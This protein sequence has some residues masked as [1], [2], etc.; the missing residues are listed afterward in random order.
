MS[1][2][3]P[4]EPDPPHDPPPARG[5]AG[6]PVV[7][8]LSLVAAG[9]LAAL[10][11][12]FIVDRATHSRTEDVFVEAHIVNIAPQLVSGRIIRVMADENDRV[13]AGQVLAEIDPIPYQDKV[14][15]A[16]RKLES[17]QAQHRMAAANLAKARK[18]VP[19]Q[20][21]ISKRNHATAIADRAKAEKSL[22]LTRQQ[23]AQGIDE[24]QAGVKSARADLL[25]AD[26]QYGRYTRLYQ[27][28]ASTQQKAQEATQARESAAAQLELAETKL[29]TALSQR[30]KVDVADADLDAAHAGEGKAAQNISLSETG[31]DQLRAEEFQVEVARREVAQAEEAL[32]SA[33]HDLDYTRIRA[34]FPGV[35]VKRYRNLG[36]FAAPGSS[37]LSMVNPDLLYVEANLEETRLPGVAPGN[38]VTIHIDAFDRPFEGRVLWINK[39]TGAEFALMPRNVVSGE[40]THVVQRVAVRIWIKPDGRWDQLRA[41]LSAHIE[42]AHSGSDPEWARRTARELTALETR[43]N[44]PPAPDSPA[45]VLAPPPAGPVQR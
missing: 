21:E 17:A 18:D 40:F 35:V 9:V 34:P 42:I 38:P 31:Y 30:L 13:D 11:V 20:V 5:I 28:E 12:V 32:R 37:V 14:A 7:I 25:L 36:D 4:T 8:T 33:Q 1:A 23:V 26:E 27:Q 24:A 6:R 16:R 10:L 43:Y 39:S 3:P 22:T 44:Q 41:G 45:D 15:E 19:I 29:A 2:A